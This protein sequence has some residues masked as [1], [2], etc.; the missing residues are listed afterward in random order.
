M[1][2][3]V[4]YARVDKPY[5]VQ[6]VDTLDI[7]EIWVDQRLAAGQNWW[8][9][10][11]RR[12]DWCEGFIYLLSPDSVNSEYCRREFELARS[13]GRPIFPIL[14]REGTVIPQSLKE[15][16]YVDFT[17]GIVMESLKMLL[18]SIQLEERA[19]QNDT[20]R[21][22]V[23][24]IPVE[25]IRQ[26]TINPATVI[27][28][29]ATAMENRQYDQAVYYLQQAKAIGFSSRFINIDLLLEEAERELAQQTVQIE[30]DREYKQI[31]DLLRQRSTRRLGW[32]F[33]LRFQKI[34]PDYDPE[35]Y[36]LMYGPNG[37]KPRIIVSNGNL[38]NGNGSGGQ[39]PPPA[40]TFNIPLLE[41]CHIPYG[42]VEVV[43]INNLGKRVKRRI[44]QPEFHSSLYPV[45][46]QQ[47]NL[48][49]SDPSGY[50]NVSWWQYSAHANQW[51]TKNPEPKPGKFKGEDHPR[52]MVNW[53]D[54]M[55]FCHWL[56]AQLGYAVSLPT[57][58]QWQ[59]AFQGE[60]GRPY[61]WGKNF[62]PTRCNSSE[63][64]FNQ[65]TSVRR[66]PNGASPFG[67]IDMA[68]N[69]W[70]WCADL[71]PSVDGKPKRIMRGGSYISPG[72]RA[73]ISFRYELG[74]ESYH[75]SIGFRIVR[76][77]V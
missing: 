64:G 23:P 45:T 63:S 40:P 53:Y 31:G 30:A 76:N 71:I 70:E 26:P 74:P 19:L 5:C 24:N 9:E 12:L 49:L 41:W 22:T 20:Q 7:H 10:I 77:S 32:E 68:G 50:A 54:A 27:R 11:L 75:N 8:K 28:L 73:H 51:R 60:D 6:I 52:E 3:F 65:T 59:R 15:I 37:S 2:L 72:E 21:K 13:L 18:N 61:P 36:F 48:F 67:V 16:Q 38:D 46:N 69:V 42:M 17:R 44:E 57:I 4:S 35:N 43:E 62:D 39:L 29:A 56:S 25:E 1:K 34:Y 58:A 47:Y 33:F 55:A 14:I 66:Y